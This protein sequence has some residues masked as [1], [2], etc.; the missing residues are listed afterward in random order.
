MIPRRRRRRRRPPVRFNW[1]ISTPVKNVFVSAFRLS[2]TTYLAPLFVAKR[3][4]PRQEVSL[5]PKWAPPPPPPPL[6]GISIRKAE[7]GG[8]SRGPYRSSN[9]RAEVIN[10]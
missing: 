3:A 1:A 5:K 4:S 9:R 8:G 2:R 10:I 7:V 6:A